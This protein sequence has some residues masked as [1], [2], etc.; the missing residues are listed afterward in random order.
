MPNWCS[1]R[2]V[3]RNENPE[4]ISSLYKNLEAWQTNARKNSFGEGWLGNIVLNS[5][6]GTVDSGAGT[7][8]RCRGDIEYMELLGAEITID[9]ETAWTPMLRMW[10]RIIDKY[11]PD[12]ELEYTAVECGSDIY[13][14]NDP[15]L[16][17]KYHMDAW[18]EAES[19]LG[20]DENWAAD[21]AEVVRVL[22]KALNSESE[23]F[24][25]LRKLLVSK[26]I[27]LTVNMWEYSPV[28]C[29]D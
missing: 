28:D 22:Q 7:D 13:C 18:D 21:K 29:W 24:D 26:D 27:P 10:Q 16:V 5:G 1:S 9:T 8:L 3:I 6:V 14:T 12:S 23:N 25:E 15:E 20:F 4:V 19:I 17:G 11:A 2:I